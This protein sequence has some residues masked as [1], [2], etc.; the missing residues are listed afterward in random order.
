MEKLHPVFYICDEGIAVRSRERCLESVFLGERVA[1]S[2]Q[3]KWRGM[4]R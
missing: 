4:K 2:E 1:D 3:A